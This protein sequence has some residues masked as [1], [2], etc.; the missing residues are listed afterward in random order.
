MK[1]QSETRSASKS[2]K[3][4]VPVVA[5]LVAPIAPVFLLVVTLLSA[6]TA[7]AQTFGCN[8]PMANDIVC[9]NS[10]AG[11]PSSEWDVDG[12]GDLTIQGFATDISVNQ[13]GTINF[14]IKTNAH[15]YTIDIYR[16]GYYSGMGARKITTITPMVALPQNQP[17][18]LTDG[19][20]QLVD[21]GNWAVSASWAV[22]SNAT[23]GIYFAH[24]IRADTG[25]DSHIV[26]IIRKDTSHSDVVFQTGDESWQAYNG[27]GGAS[28]YGPDGEYNVSNRAYKVSYNRPFTTRGFGFESATWVFG[29][30]YPMVRWLESNGYDVTYTTHVDGVRNGALLRNHKVFLASGHDEYWSGPLRT[31]LESAR[32]AGVNLAFFTGNEVFWKTRWENSIDGTNTPY[33]TLTCYK[34]TLAGAKIDPSS[35]WTGTWRDHSFSPPSDGGRPE[36]SLTGTLFMVNGPGPDNNGL[37]IQV[38]ASDG[39][40]RFWRNTAY[41][42][43]ASGQVATLPLG[44]LGY[45]WDADIDNGSRPA[46]A[47]PLSTATYGLTTDLLLDNG[48]S[49]GAGTSTHH[50]MMYRAASHALVFGAG[51]VQWSWGL[52]D[53]HDNLYS[54]ANPAPDPNM[55]Q[56]TVNLLADMNANPATLQ[57]GLTLATTSTDSTPPTSTITS[58]SS[59]ST[60]SVGVPTTIS[61]TAADVGGGLV[62]AVEVSVDSGGSWHPAAGRGNWTYPWTPSQIGSTTIMSRAVDDSGN[63]QS[64]PTSLSLNVIAHDCPCSAWSASAAPA[65]VDSGDGNSLEVGVKFRADFNGFITGIRF[66]KSPANTGTHVGNLWTSTGTLLGSATFVNETNS[67]WQQV[68]F[69]NPISITA[70]TTYVASYFAPAGHYSVT[71]FYFAA[72]GLDDPPIHLLANGVDGSN[73]IYIYNSS[74]TFPNFSS[75]ASNYWVD[76]VFFPSTSMPT[77]P[78]A[79]VATPSSLSFTAPQGNSVPPPPSQS[80]SLYNQGSGVLNWTATSSQSWLHLSPASGATP[81]TLSVSVDPTGLAPGNYAGT[82]TI[83][84]PSATNPSQTVSVNLSVTTVLLYSNIAVTG[85]QGWA[86]SPLGLSTGWSIVNQAVQYGG[87]GNTQVFAGNSV[88]TDYTLAVPI[89]LSNLQNWPGGIRARVNPATGAGYALWL[90]PASGQIILYRNSAWDINQGLVQLGQHSVAF[91]TVNFHTLS[92][93]FL[94]NQISVLYDGQTLITVTDNT[95]RNG[96]VALEGDTQVLSFG[97]TLVTSSNPSLNNGTLAAA[98]NSLSFTANFQGANPPAQTVPVTGGGGGS[99][100]WTASSNASWLNVSPTSGATPA[101]LQISVSSSSLGAGSYSGTVSVASLGAVNGPLP[102]NVS[103]TV[104]PPPPSLVVSPSSLSFSATIGQAVP[105]SQTLAV[106]N[107][108]SGSFSWSASTDASWLIASPASGSTPQNVNVSVNPT[109]LIAGNYSGH[110]VVSASGIANSPRSIPVNLQVLTQDLSE[111]FA[112]LANGWI[113]SPMG[114]AD[115]WTVSNGTY[116]YAGYGLSQSCAGN[117]AW[118]NF[119]FDTNIGLSSLSNWPGGI[120]ARVNPM[121]GAGY[122]VWLYPASGRAFLFR[123]G[124]W[125]INDS[126][127]T[128]LAQAS[129]TFDTSTVHDLGASFQGNQ[130]S[131]YWDGQP[132]MTATDST[133]S[134]GLVCL[135]ADSQPISYSN[136]R[137]AGSS[138]AVRLDTPAPASLVFSAPVGATSLSSQTVNISAGTASTTWA[139]QTNAP[140]LSAQ[141]STT[142]TPGVITVSANPTGLPASTYNATVTVFA[143]GATNSPI[144]IPVT[145]TFMQYLSTSPPSLQFFGAVGLNPLAQNVQISNLGTGTLNW[146][147]SATSSWLGL[148][149]ASGSAPSV[150][151]AAP[152]VSGL[153]A[154]SY[155]DTIKISSSNATNGPNNVPVSLQLGS[156]LFSDN[157]S[158]GAG[159][160]TI[161][162][163]GFASGWTVGSNLYTFDGSGHTQSFAGSPI[164]SD[165]TFSV[166]FQLSST[167]DYPGGIRGRLNTTTGAGYAVWIYPAEGILKLYRVGQWNIDSGFALLGQ[168]AAGI[169]KFDTNPHHLR[170]YFVGSGIRVY[171]DDALAI[172]ATDATYAQGGIALDVSNR[173]ISFSKVT[174]IS[175]P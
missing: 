28:L 4:L 46:G 103:L 83:A 16:M 92:L 27:Y 151:S 131:V 74:S 62:A 13:G 32:D 84:A 34:E 24:L 174:V 12:A 91:D 96:L 73:G 71:T 50:M 146:S 143:P 86:F 175:L 154:G 117:A 134:T 161:G 60:I 22:P 104:V 43:L 108:G 156:L 33:R 63:L 5:R 76:P 135:D 17:S 137:V 56:A 130:I 109:G 144:S 127:L 69:P 48:A 149:P 89:K 90:Y 39:K 7:H 133:Y 75:Q 120:R 150:L 107:A 19:T 38:P 6:Q 141:A 26:F 10:K 140:W 139:I 45:E 159:N 99:L 11:S 119:T 2:C 129:L 166:D 94:G 165:Y 87:I 57:T 124:T 55:Q 160:W 125:N 77:A 82:I 66:Y 97:N 51:T 54:F 81:Q 8:P 152:N 170:L 40:M 85:L 68:N 138:A 113:I 118:S 142:L 49:Y 147:A 9:E 14:K 98:S 47:F 67:G 112:N 145:L 31:N 164:W 79:L 29:S 132:I 126:S 158:S 80:I 78:P 153:S 148:S 110:V 122:V 121:T 162:P 70:N 163:L 123:V 37:S 128:Q 102:I 173:P 101:N 23:S 136:V 64:A 95:Y 155:A 115:G 168:S 157:F 1:F 171:Y 21:C 59:G 42:G 88:W 116:R 106:S 20:T 114:H 18:C 25:G 30:E 15:S 35:T 3:C 53:Q 44:T 72:S 61:G 58:P 41:A 100:A 105:A 111:S 93:S 65:Q 36:N 169:L 52:D 167:N 172:S